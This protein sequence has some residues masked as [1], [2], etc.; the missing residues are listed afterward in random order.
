ML[1][2]WITIQPRRLGLLDGFINIGL[3]AIPFLIS[4]GAFILEHIATYGLQD[5]GLAKHRR[6]VRVV[7]FCAAGAGALAIL[8][9]TFGLVELPR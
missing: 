6:L 8:A 9:T 3:L 4:L 7:G 2:K 1:L 5:S